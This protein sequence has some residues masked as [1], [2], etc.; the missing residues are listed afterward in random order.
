MP[1]KTVKSK[2]K[3]IPKLRF[4]GF[5]GV[6]EKERFGDVFYF[7]TTNSF[8]RENLNYESGK[9]KNI[10]Y[11]DIHTKFKMR[12]D[13]TKEIVPF[14]NNEIALNKIPVDNFCKNGD[15]IIVDA[16]EDY[17]DIGKSIEI[18]KLNKEK[19]LAGLHTLQARPKI[20][21]FYTGFSGCLMKSQK[22]RSQIMIIAQGTKVLSISTGRLANIF[23]N[24]PTI[25]EQR[26]I[27]DF[28]GEVDKWIENLQAQKEALKFYKKGIMQKI[29][30]QELRFKDENG[31]S[32]PEW[33]EKELRGVGKIITGTT[34]PTVNKD[35]YGG[36]FPWVTPTDI[37]SK[38]DILTSAKLLTKKG[39]EKGR[40]VSKNSLL[41]TC[42]ASIGKNAILRVDG[43][44]NQQI[45]A[46]TP[47]DK[48]DVDFFY[49]L[50]EKNKNLLIKFAGAGGMQM[51]NKTDFSNI[52]F[53]IPNLL[54]QQKIA[55]F[56]TSVDRVVESKECQIILAEEWKN[57]LLQRLFV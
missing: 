2:T 33:K 11:G 18:I 3:K 19:V 27:A 4:L 46:I 17:V 25:P 22:I 20:N 34:P 50:L 52:K 56:L 40:F 30:S 41:V 51:L 53:K 24:F 48:N 42:I 7:I 13:V 38:K 47:N 12:F 45:N 35:F 37:D 15:L 43:S 49:Y 1:I 55:K 31:K 5:S 39:M 21:T 8:S 23:L 26:K 14:V 54:E 16:S 10:H 32:F 29:F 28:L 6:W 9:V 44:C 57:G 36:K